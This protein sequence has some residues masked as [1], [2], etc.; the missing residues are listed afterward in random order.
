MRIAGAQGL[1]AFPAQRPRR[2][3]VHG[4]TIGEIE[5]PAAG[6]NQKPGKPFLTSPP[7]VVMMFG[8]CL[9]PFLLTILS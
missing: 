6:L 9:V 4:M 2:G 3:P 1:A 5:G 8:R 7:V